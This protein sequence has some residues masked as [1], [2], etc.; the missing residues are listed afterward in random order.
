M[1]SKRTDVR[2]ETFRCAAPGLT[3]RSFRVGV[4]PS[5]LCLVHGVASATPDSSA[6]FGDSLKRRDDRRTLGGVT[7]I[8]SA[9]SQFGLEASALDLSEPG[10][11]TPCGTVK[12]DALVDEFASQ[13]HGNSCAAVLE[14]GE[15]EHR[16]ELAS[17]Q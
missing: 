6:P 16:A 3:V 8:T 14:T 5:A 17:S 9:S 10:E 2:G 11:T 4:N 12:G 15:A 13:L 7:K 1:C